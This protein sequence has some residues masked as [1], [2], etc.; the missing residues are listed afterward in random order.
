QGVTHIADALADMIPDVRNLPGAGVV[1]E[2]DEDRG[3]AG[4][5]KTAQ[6]IELCSS[7]QCAL[8][9][10]GDLLEHVVDT[11]AGPRGLHDHR[12]DDERRVFVAPESNKGEK[13]REHRDDHQVDGQRS[14]LERPFREVEAHTTAPTRADGLSGLGAR[15][16]R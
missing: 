12:L 5:C 2:I 7:L 16:A 11:G 9:P 6:K 1:L 10:L 3:Y 15:L 13:S 4:A 14:V 8:E